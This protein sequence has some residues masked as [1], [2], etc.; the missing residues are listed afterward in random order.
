MRTTNVAALPAFRS[1]IHQRVDILVDVFYTPSVLS[2]RKTHDSMYHHPADRTRLLDQRRTHS[3]PTRLREKQP[4][5]LA[6]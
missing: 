3:M 1:R 4:H 5:Y 2:R 6:T